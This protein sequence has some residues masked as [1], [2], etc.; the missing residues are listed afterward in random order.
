MYKIKVNEHYD[1]EILNQ[2]NILIINGLRVIMDIQK[3]SAGYFH[4]IMEN[5]SYKAEL[6]NY[7]ETEKICKFKIN[8]NYYHLHIRDQYDELIQQLGLDITERK[9]VVELKAPMPGM[10]LNIFIKEGDEVKKG[11]SLLILEAMKMENSI[12]SPGNLKIGSISVKSS[13]KVEKIN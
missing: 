3:I 11:D 13:Q 1:F 9:K 12:K 10:V 2:N 4:I 8:N 5:K 6:L 7:D